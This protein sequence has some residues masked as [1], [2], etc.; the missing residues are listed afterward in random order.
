MIEDLSKTVAIIVV[1]IIASRVT[2][3]SSVME[4][5]YTRNLPITVVVQWLARGRTY[6]RDP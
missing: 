3:T 2:A 5:E 1:V 4:A 6:Y